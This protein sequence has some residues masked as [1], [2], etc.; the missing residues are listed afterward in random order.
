MSEAIALAK[1][2]A[3]EPYAFLGVTAAS[4][5]VAGALAPLLALLVTQSFTV[6]TLASCIVAAAAVRLCLIPVLG[7]LL[8]RWNPLIVLFRCEIALAALTLVTA[9]ALLHGPL[10]S[11]FWIAFFVLSAVIQSFEGPA[12]PKVV[13]KIVAGKEL[14][15]FTSWETA[16]ASFA[17][18]A[19]PAL[20]GLFLLFWPTEKALLIVLV[21][22]SLLTLPIYAFMRRRFGGLFPSA[23]KAIG[24]AKTLQ[25]HAWNWVDGIGS[26]FRFRWAIAT[27]RYLGMQVFLELSVI[28]PT[29]G[30]LLPYLV[31][32]RHW[33]ASWLGW[34]E[35]ASGAGLVAGSLLAP[36]AMSLVGRWPL[37][38][39]STYATAA[40]VFLCGVSIHFDNRA[41]LSAALFCANAALGLR[42]QTGAAQRRLAIPDRFRARAVSVHLTLNA[43]AAQIGV[44][45]AAVW[46]TRYSPE[47]WCVLSGVLL[48]LLAITLPLVPGYRKLVGMEVDDA[49]D[50]YEREFPGAFAPVTP[51][52]A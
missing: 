39:G 45:A 2:G 15:V 25:A 13:L 38:V 9:L 33:E 1:R 26:G 49:K 32:E 12:F 43:L 40:G 29:F 35:A 48:S 4:R 36:K 24:E 21:T 27:E 52:A 7:P 18:F 17:R 10:A 6:E 42:M 22:P 3:K 44:A 34:F 46:L 11:G 16:M 51:K 8:D 14:T 23:A 28:V 30:I 19:G 41:G 20:A 31:A 37:G 5:L 50:F 47:S